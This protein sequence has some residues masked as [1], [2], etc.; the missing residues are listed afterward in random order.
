MKLMIAHQKRSNLLNKNISTDM[1]TISNNNQKKNR[2][3]GQ[4]KKESPNQEVAIVVF[5]HNC[6]KHMYTLYLERS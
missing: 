6:K 5:V 1:R 3:L 4:F 2:V